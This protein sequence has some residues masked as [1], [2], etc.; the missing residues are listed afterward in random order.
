MTCGRVSDAASSGVVVTCRGRCET[1][2]PGALYAACI[3]RFP[4]HDFQKSGTMVR[5]LV[6]G[7]VEED[8]LN[9]AAGSLFIL[10][11][12]AVGL[13]VS[14]GL[15]EVSLAV[16]GPY[17]AESENVGLLVQFGDLA[18]IVFIRPPGSFAGPRV[19]VEHDDKLEMRI[20]CDT[21]CMLDFI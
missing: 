5:G 3:P 8:A 20:A 7:F 4:G 9:I 18:D 17:V 12:G 1:Y 14:A 19:W 21:A 2:Q 6:G 15:L 16:L 11:P 13:N 10:R